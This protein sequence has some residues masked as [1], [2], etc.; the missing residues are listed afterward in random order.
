MNK[1]E[2]ATRIAN[3]IANYYTTADI[4]NELYQLLILQ[5][6]YNEA[7]KLSKENLQPEEINELKSELRS[8]I[9]LL[10]VNEIKDMENNLTSV[11]DEI[12]R[13]AS[14]RPTK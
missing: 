14:I 5:Y 7:V 12:K 11:K 10:S 9:I 8:L 1:F 3:H 2:T 4:Q 13:I 6:N